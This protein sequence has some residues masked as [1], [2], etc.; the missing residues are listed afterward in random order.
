MP[1]SF[2]LISDTSKKDGPSALT[3]RLALAF[4]AAQ[5]KAQSESK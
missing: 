4:I 2:K 1:P 3:T 5:A